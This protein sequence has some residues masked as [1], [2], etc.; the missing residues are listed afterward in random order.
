MRLEFFERGRGW[1]PN[2]RGTGVL[3]VEIPSSIKARQV[4]W[5]FQVGTVGFV[6][7]TEE[8]RQPTLCE[9]SSQ[10]WSALTGFGIPISR[11]DEGELSVLQPNARDV[12]VTRAT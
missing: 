3:V 7:T 10:E 12:P 5:K 9:T 1:H 4:S 2:E 6:G 8:D 11:G